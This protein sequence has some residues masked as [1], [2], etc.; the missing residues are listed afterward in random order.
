MFFSRPRPAK[1]SAPGRGV[2]A[3]AAQTPRSAVSKMKNAKA[4]KKKSVLK[5]PELTCDELRKILRIRCKLVLND[6][7]EKK[8]NFRYTREKSEKLA[9]QERGGRKYLPP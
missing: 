9:H 8:F 5:L 4:K 7:A 3:A 6:F 2:A 1:E